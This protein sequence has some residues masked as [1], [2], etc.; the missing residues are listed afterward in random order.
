[1]KN[2][3]LTNLNSPTATRLK[4]EDCGGLRLTQLQILILMCYGTEAFHSDKASFDSDA[5]VFRHN[6]T[7]PAKTISATM[8]RL[9]ANQLSYEE[10]Q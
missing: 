4:V 3:H 8:R 5:D 1:M 2:M 6:S 10:I 7:D 9:V